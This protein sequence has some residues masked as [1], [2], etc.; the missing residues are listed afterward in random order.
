MLIGCY[1]SQPLYG[2]NLATFIIGGAPIL[3]VSSNASNTL[4]AAGTECPESPGEFDPR[5]LF[6]YGCSRYFQ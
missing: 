3:S 1:F 4:L 2:S 6:W 5:L